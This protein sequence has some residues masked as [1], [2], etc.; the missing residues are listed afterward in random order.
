MKIALVCIVKNE[1]KYIEEWVNYHKKIGFDD[2]IMYQNDWVC[3]LDLPYLKKLEIPGFHKQMNA[4]HHFTTNFRKNYD[5]AAF[6]DC[7]EFL[8]LKKHKNVHEFISEYHN[9]WGIGVNWQFF[10]A[11]GK[12]NSG[13]HK[14]SLLK[15]FTKKQ[16]NV[17]QHV[18]TIMNLKCGGVMIL[19]HNPNTPLMDTN[20]KFFNGPFNPNGPIDVVQLNHYHHKSYED[21]LIRC[22]RGQSDH[23]PRKKPEQWDTEKFVF[24]DVDDF[25]AITFMYK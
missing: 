22:E 20:R 1:D 14:K 21:W 17:D 23:C 11:D 25:S 8:V 2:I 13:E 7:D 12:M 10:G 3:Q 9:D 24:C 15:Q 19:P 6:F 5:W 16:K 4:Y 18:K